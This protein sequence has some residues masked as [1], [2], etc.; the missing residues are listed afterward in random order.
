MKNN[1]INIII[2]VKN[3]YDTLYFTLKN[4]LSDNY[5]NLKVLVSD[6]SSLKN[7][8]FY[9]SFNDE[10]LKIIYTNSE[11]EMHE[12]YEY[13]LNNINDGWVGFIGSDDGFIPGS[14]TYLNNLINIYNKIHAIRFSSNYY[15]W[16]DKKNDY[17]KIILNSKNNITIRS[18][19]KYLNKVIHGYIDYDQLPLIYN[20]GFVKYDLLKNIYK[21]NKFF[22]SKCPDVYSGV[23]IS[24]NT[25]EYLYV[26][27]PLF[28]YGSSVHSSGNSLHQTSGNL[29]QNTGAYDFFLKNNWHRNCPILIN[30]IP[31]RSLYVYFIESFFTACDIYNVAITKDNLKTIYISSLCYKSNDNINIKIWAKDFKK[32]N[33]IKYIANE[34]LQILFYKIFKLKKLAIN[35]LRK[36]IV[37]Y[38]CKKI[39]NINDA[40][41]Y[42]RY[43]KKYM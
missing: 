40:M 33:N 22:Y 17:S 39:K 1:I 34:N 21:K 4:I 6:N 13:A 15:L 29:K 32:I 9:K 2:P 24:L 12:N 10:R 7:K 11:L 26:N 23:A 28:F 8:E 36:K 20:G 43:V 16:P 25:N 35:Y 27:R 14:I 31:I 41:D 19:K 5:T 18:S 38:K 37:V 42:L 3:R 30:K